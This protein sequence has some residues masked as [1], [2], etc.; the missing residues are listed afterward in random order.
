[1]NTFLFY[2]A[3][4]NAIMTSSTSS[5]GGPSVLW[6]VLEGK[7]VKTGDGKELGEITEFSENYIRVEKGALR[8]ENYW[9]PKYVADAY[10]GHTLWLLISEEEVLERFKYGGDEEELKKP[11]SSEQYTRDF[12]TFKGSGTGKDREYRSDLDESIRVVEN[13][14]NIRNYK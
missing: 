14:E 9:I 8:K 2:Y 4:N 7:K 10:D 5:G 11:P 12:E 6:N 1:M 3:L 13:Y